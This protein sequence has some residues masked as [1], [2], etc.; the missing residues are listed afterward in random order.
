MKRSAMKIGALLLACVLVAAACSSG[1]DTS[2]GDT[3]PSGSSEPFKIGVVTSLSGNYEFLG[4]TTEA[5]VQA[6]VAVLNDRGGV[7]GRTV[8]AVVCNDETN[9]EAARACYQKLVQSDGVDVMVGFPL[10][11][12]TE[13][14][15]PMIARDQIPTWI[16]GGAYGGRDMN[17]QEYMFSGLPV[18][19]DVLD[20]VFEWGA[21]EGYSTA[22]IVTTEDVT[23]EPCREWAG[24]DAQVRHGIE[25]IG[26]NT[27]Q[28]T[29]QSAAPQMA[30]IDRSADFV[31]VCV[32][33]GGGVVAA[34]AFEQAGLTMPAVAV[35]SQGVPFVANAMNGRVSDDKILVAGFC[36]LGV[37]TGELS[38]DFLCYDS[39]KEYVDTAQRIAPSVAPDVL[40]AHAYDGAIILA[41][42]ANETD[43]SPQ[44]IVRYIE[45]LEDFPAAMGIYTFSESQR[46]GITSQEI[47]LGVF[48]GGAW[49]LYDPLNLR[50]Q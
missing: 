21:G 9:P 6:A 20:A 5:G 22:W 16:L 39:A 28:A 10:G 30:E 17:G 14:V 42:A 25:V 41:T 24:Q 34:Q 40:G 37:I 15:A 49:H 7:H 8:E 4:K 43:G 3:S 26:T 1:D 33:G 36:T 44:E 32:S 31:F 50:T 18:T 29:A 38:Q 11:A 12:A 35:H 45:N 23:G 47:L 2:T 48:R 19:E 27:M 46:R 13:A